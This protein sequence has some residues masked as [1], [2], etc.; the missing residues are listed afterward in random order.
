M[1]HAVA[2]RLGDGVGLL[3]DL[4][5]HE[6]LEAG[7][8]G[9]LVVPVELDELALDRA[10][11]VGAQEAGTVGRDRDEVAVLGEVHLARLAQERR[12]VRGE[13][14][15]AAADAD[16][17]RALMPRADEQ[18]GVVAVDRDEGEVTL[19]LVEREARRLDEVA[20]VVLLDQVADRL[21]VGLGGEDVAR[22]RRGGSRSSR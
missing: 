19:E 16:D 20:V 9:A 12:R 18:A 14:R 3:V 2:D 22:S 1:A 5:Q 10:A 21:G 11:V 17:E 13:E 15:L 4:L 7:L 6:R 8:L